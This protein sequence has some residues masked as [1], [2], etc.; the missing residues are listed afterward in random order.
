[1]INKIASMMIMIMENIFLGR[2]G[3]FLFKER[4]IIDD[5]D[6]KMVTEVIKGK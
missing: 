4:R 1:M 6:K 5:I 2:W 3:L